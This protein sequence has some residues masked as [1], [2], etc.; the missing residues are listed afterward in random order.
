[1]WQRYWDYGFL[2]EWSYILRCVEI[3]FAEMLQNKGWGW[4]EWNYRW[5]K[6]V[7]LKAFV[8]TGWWVCKVSLF[9]SVFERLKFLILK[10][11][12]INLKKSLVSGQV[13]IKILMQ[14]FQVMLVNEPYIENQCFTN[15]IIKI[16]N[17]LWLAGGFI[18]A[19]E[20]LISSAVFK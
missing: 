1:M 16:W 5:T 4:V 14:T 18:N 20:K 7:I 2:K 17:D 6:V 12:K 19:A 13:K 9:R 8:E 10:C 3:I 11:V 15:I